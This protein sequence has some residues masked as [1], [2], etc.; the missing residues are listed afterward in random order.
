MTLHATSELLNARVAHSWLMSLA[1]GSGVRRREASVSPVPDSHRPRTISRSKRGFPRSAAKSGSRNESLVALLLG[2]GAD[3]N[4]ISAAWGPPLHAAVTRGRPPVVRQLLAAGADP[5]A[6]NSAAEA[7][8]D[9]APARPDHRAILAV[10]S[11]FGILP[12]AG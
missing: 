12:H 10:F 6:R 5:R 4:A 11:E 9:V 2:H 3:P 8:F 1:S 7:V